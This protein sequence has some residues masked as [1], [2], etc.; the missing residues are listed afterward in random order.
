MTDDRGVYEIEAEGEKGYRS[1][2]PRKEGFNPKIHCMAIDSN[3]SGQMFYPVCS[4]SALIL[5]NN[6]HDE[7]WPVESEV[8]VLLSFRCLDL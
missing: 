7:Y 6:R 2:R 4:G 3:S 5:F 8:L 1:R